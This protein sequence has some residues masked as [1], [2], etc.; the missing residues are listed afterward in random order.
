MVP[1][2][3]VEKTTPKVAK[4]DIII[5]CSSKSFKST[6]KE[7]ANKRNESIP[8]IKVILKSI[9]LTTEY[10]KIR[11]DGKEKPI[12]KIKSDK[13]NERSINPIVIGNL[14]NLKFRYIKPADIVTK[15]ED[16]SNIFKLIIPQN[17]Q[18]QSF[19]L[20]RQDHTTFQ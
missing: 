10:A 8:P 7:P 4:I 16:V 14:R 3:N 18:N 12:K 2:K 15:R 6:C 5:F 11:I 1:T 9:L 20:Q 17:H 19:R 13:I